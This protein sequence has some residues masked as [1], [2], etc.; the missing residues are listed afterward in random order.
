[1]NANALDRASHDLDE[2]VRFRAIKQGVGYALSAEF[3]RHVL[4]TGCRKCFNIT[5]GKDG[6][7]VSDTEY[8]AWFEEWKKEQKDAAP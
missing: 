8:P 1:M 4:R 6:R 7:L 2:Y 3:F 5:V